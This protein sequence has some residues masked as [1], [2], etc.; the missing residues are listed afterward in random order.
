MR[1]ATHGVLIARGLS[2]GLNVDIDTPPDAIEKMLE[3]PHSGPGPPTTL[4]D[5]RWRIFRVVRS[6]RSRLELDCPVDC[7]TCPAAQVVR[8][9]AKGSRVVQDLE[10]R[11]T[12]KEKTMAD[13]YTRED[14]MKLDLPAL[15]KIGS[16]AP[17]KIP[18]A[19]VYASPKEEL[20]DKI[21][22]KQGGE[23]APSGGGGAPP[24]APPA[25]EKKRAARKGATPP[26]PSTPPEDPG[27]GGKNPPEEPPAGPA[28]TGK[29][30]P[31]R[32][33]RPSE[34]PAGYEDDPAALL[35]IAISGLIRKADPSSK[36][37]KHLQSEFIPKTDAAI[38]SLESSVAEIMEALGLIV[39]V[40]AYTAFAEPI[41]DLEGATPLEKL[42]DLRSR[43]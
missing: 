12:E 28:P 42:R 34:A 8:C 17:I 40:M 10:S 39:D 27:D 13:K 23:G 24:A 29:Q 32:K 43:F 31:A 3:D 35:E 2:V 19:E 22:T 38:E 18:R 26:P 14:L 41:T 36:E 33:G 5:L 20:I 16:S 4:D 30:T 37:L 7:P 11:W 15:Y 6:Y 1:T 25:T 9:W 21:L